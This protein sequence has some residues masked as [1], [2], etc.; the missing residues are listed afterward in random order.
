MLSPEGGS[1]D[2]A[3]SLAGALGP[4]AAS[5]L[6]TPAT[7]ALDN[8]SM[9]LTTHPLP[10]GTPKCQP[11]RGRCPLAVWGTFLR[12]GSSERHLTAIWAPQDSL[13]G[14]LRRPAVWGSELQPAE[15]QEGPSA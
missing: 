11:F 8:P 9:G 14:M 7:G 1:E 3:V 5:G 13:L 6:G 12:V 4:K 15:R 2:L 10:Q